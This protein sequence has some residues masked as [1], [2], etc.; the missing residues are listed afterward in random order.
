MRRHSHLALTLLLAG[1]IT[2]F[3]IAGKPT[4]ST[5]SSGV[6]SHQLQ[7]LLKNQENA[8][9]GLV[10]HVKFTNKTKTKGTVTINMNHHA[11]KDAADSSTAKTAEAKA[12]EEKEFQISTKTK[13]E[14]V[15]ISK[16]KQ[17][18]KEAS[19]TDVDKGDLVVVIV[20][21]KSTDK[22]EKVLI[23][24]STKGDDSDKKQ[25]K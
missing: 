18:H 7:S 8:V 24:E 2:G 21:A 19:F 11:K 15:T 14:T 1:L 5:R 17:E 20:K 13:I 22:A 12:S 9:T 25:A 10:V 4:V 6:S 3:G 23:L 16:S